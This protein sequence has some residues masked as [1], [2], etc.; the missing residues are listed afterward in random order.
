MT[1]LQ[2]LREDR[3]KM[4]K[5][6]SALIDANPGKKWTPENQAT[7]DA[8]LAKIGEIDGMINRLTDLSDTLAG[9][10]V[11]GMNGPA[12]AKCHELWR[13]ESG[14]DIP[15]LAKSHR[16]SDFSDNVGERIKPG[17][18]F[19]AMFTGGGTPEIRNAL[20][21][22][23]ESAG[24]YSVPDY[25]SSQIIDNAR[26][27]SCVVQAGALTVPL[28]SEKT[29]IMKIAADPTV[30][31]RL[32]NAA[33][34]ESDPTFAGVTFQARSLAVLVKVSRELLEDSINIGEALTM[35]LSGAIAAEL[36]RVCLIGSGVAPQPLGILGT[37]GINT[38][39]MGA[40]GLVP[41]AYTQLLT[42]Y[43]NIL[44]GN[45][46]DP[47]A[48]IMAPRS[49]IRYAG[50]VDTTGQPMRK[51]ELLANVPFMATSKIGITDTVGASNDCS[52]AFLGSFRHLLIGIR[53]GLR[54]EMN[55]SLFAGNHQMGFIAHMRADVAVTQPK[56][57]T[58]ITGIR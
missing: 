17:E 57:F 5:E 29:T 43:Q 54:I 45:I 8:K 28:N 44:E 50:L 14:R 19:K 27:K 12:Q 7:Y 41:I 55:P 30:A 46:E 24:G 25:V 18:L 47:S 36:D 34:A 20:S 1:K 32:E 26:A 49:L 33:I 9:N 48:I 15:V 22:G 16:L 42:A 21:E 52:K 6:V 40:A 56:A 53:S 4:A 3:A 51:P 39:S 38:V 37:D 13:D 23:T 31:W 11:T 35:A 58:V 10:N 2:Q